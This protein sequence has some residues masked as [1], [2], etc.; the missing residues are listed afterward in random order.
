[1]LGLETIDDCKTVTVKKYTLSGNQLSENTLE[2]DYDDAS[3]FWLNGM[4]LESAKTELYDMAGKLIVTIY[5]NK[6]ISPEKLI[7]NI[8]LTMETADLKDGATVQLI[9]QII[10]S[11][12]A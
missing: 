4:E 9:A 1:M 11:D 12:A 6:D 2:T 10:P 5:S 8:S 3:T 7:T